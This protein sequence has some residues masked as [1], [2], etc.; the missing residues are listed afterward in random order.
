MSN[1][2]DVDIMIFKDL[3]VKNKNAQILIID[4]LVT[5]YPCQNKNIEKYYDL[6]NI[7]LSLEPKENKQNMII[8]IKTLIDDFAEEE[9][10]EKYPSVFGHEENDEDNTFAL[11]LCEFS[12]WLGFKVCPVCLEEYGE[13]TFIAL[14]LYEMTFF[15]FTDKQIEETRNDLHERV[16][17][18]ESGE[19][20]MIPWEEVK[21]ELDLLIEED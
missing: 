3:I 7:L 16:K 13:L 10:K 14:C 1:T 12:E 18:V 8:S 11:E 5:E 2:R 17:R 20:K 15:G 6:Y 19:E 9:E 4:L 21:K